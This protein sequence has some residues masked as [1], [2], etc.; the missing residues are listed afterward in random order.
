VHAERKKMRGERGGVARSAM[1]RRGQRRW[2]RRLPLKGC[3][4]MEARP[5]AAPKVIVVV[6]AVTV[7]AATATAA[8]AKAAAAAAVPLIHTINERGQWILRHIIFV[9]LNLNFSSSLLLPLPST[10]LSYSPGRK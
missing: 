6:L 5:G 1:Q 7:T 8:T 3:Q 10:S 4:M 9:K 2:P